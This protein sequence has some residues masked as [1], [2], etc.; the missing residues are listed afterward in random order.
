VALLA[1]AAIRRESPA[2]S[3]QLGTLPPVTCYVAL[4]SIRLRL[5]FTGYRPLVTA[6][7]ALASS[8]STLSEPIS[9]FVND[10]PIRIASDW[11]DKLFDSSRILKVSLTS[12]K[13]LDA[14]D[15]VLSN[16]SLRLDFRAV[17]DRSVTFIERRRNHPLAEGADEDAESVLWDIQLHTERLFH[18]GTHDKPGPGILV[19]WLFQRG[20]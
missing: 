18:F 9:A 7:P 1:R 20:T 10:C 3:S 16:L 11:S 19:S 17:E 2:P 6:R 15:R 5:P 14:F 12:E 8:R 13:L 4:R